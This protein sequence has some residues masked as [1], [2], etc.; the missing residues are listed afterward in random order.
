MSN[1]AEPA[2]PLP[3]DEIPIEE[4]ARRQGVRAVDSLDDLARPA[5]WESDAEFED[6]LDDLY[7]SRR[8]DVS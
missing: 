8:T 6:F 4:L 5:S 7:R 2:V 3:L 1:A